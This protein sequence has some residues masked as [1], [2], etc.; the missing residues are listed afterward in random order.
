MR[1]V[2]L[3][4]LGVAL[5]VVGVGL[6]SVPASLI[7]AGVSFVAIAYVA[8]YLEVSSDEDA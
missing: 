7:V 8:R 6:L 5:V 3:A 4:L 2:A 1:E